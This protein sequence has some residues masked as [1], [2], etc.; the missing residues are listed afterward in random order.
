MLESCDKM[1]HTRI[2]RERHDRPA[3]P[4]HSFAGAAWLP[5]VAQLLYKRQF[6][7]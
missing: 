6:N 1:Q 4:I 7:Q 3:I 2:R 5:Q